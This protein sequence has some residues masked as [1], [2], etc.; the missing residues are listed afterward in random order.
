MTKIMWLLRKKFFWFELVSFMAMVF[1]I[2]SVLSLYAFASLVASTFGSELNYGS[3]VNALIA[4]TAVFVGITVLLS[5]YARM[6]RPAGF[7]D[8]L[9]NSEEI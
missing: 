6:L 7:I 9:K 5:A 2:F 3:E 1:G 4:L 8:Y